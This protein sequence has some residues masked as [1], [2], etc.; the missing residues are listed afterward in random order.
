[1]RGRASLADS[2]RPAKHRQQTR[3]REQVETEVSEH[4]PQ[5][6]AERQRNPQ[7]RKGRGHVVAE[8]LRIAEQVSGL[9]E[10]V[11]VPAG[12]WQQREAASG[13]H[14]SAVGRAEELLPTAGVRTAR[15]LPKQTTPAEPESRFP[16]QGRRAKTRELV[17]PGDPPDKRSNAQ[18]VKPAAGRSTW[19]RE[20][21]VKKTG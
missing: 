4:L 13:R 2:L 3:Q 9:R 15:S 14:A 21:C 7:R 17:S 5:P 6:Q 20:L 11:A 10:V 18:K 8:K 12:E 16:S 1:M 19:A